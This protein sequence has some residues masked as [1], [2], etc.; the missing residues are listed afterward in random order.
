MDAFVLIVYPFSRGF[1]WFVGAQLKSPIR[2]LCPRSVAKG[3]SVEIFCI[4]HLHQYAWDLYSRLC[5]Y[6]LS[7]YI[8]YIYYTLTYIYIFIY[9]IYIV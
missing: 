9:Y 4:T 8:L 3:S 5:M 6:G 1:K 2:A 7:T